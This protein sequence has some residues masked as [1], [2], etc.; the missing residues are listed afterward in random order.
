MEYAQWM[1]RA[2]ILFRLHIYFCLDWDNMFGLGSMCAR[3]CLAKLAASDCN[4][5][6]IVI[7]AGVVYLAIQCE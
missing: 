4:G 2:V 3:V 5:K 1:M 6:F 7:S